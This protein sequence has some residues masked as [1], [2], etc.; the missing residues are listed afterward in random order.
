MCAG[1]GEG[2]EWNTFRVEHILLVSF[3]A[4]DKNGA[5]CFGMCR[6]P[7]M[8][9]HRSTIVRRTPGED[10][11]VKASHGSGCQVL[12]RNFLILLWIS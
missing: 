7:N 2:E 6:V 1:E 10:V 11:C 4:V 9:Y 12:N 3:V 5:N 8:C